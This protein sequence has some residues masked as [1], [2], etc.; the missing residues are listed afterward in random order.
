MKEKIL[1]VTPKDCRW[2]YMGASSKGGQKANKTAS[3]VRCTH[4]LSGAVGKST[5][6]RSQAKNKQQAFVRMTEHPKFKAWIRLEI[7]KIQRDDEGIERKI[8]KDMQKVKVEMFVNGKWQ[9][10]I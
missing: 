9:E 4:E 10:E 6:H 5:E 3:G 2:D 8:D 1:S 7:A